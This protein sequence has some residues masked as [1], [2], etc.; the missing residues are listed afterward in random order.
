MEIHGTEHLDIAVVFLPPPIK[1]TFSGTLL[2][3]KT[4][5]F[6]LV[7]KSD[8]LILRSFSLHNHKFD[9]G[10][11]I[12]HYEFDVFANSDVLAACENA[13]LLQKFPHGPLHVG[14]KPTFSQLD[15][16]SPRHHEMPQQQQYVCE[17]KASL[18][19]TFKNIRICGDAN[20]CLA[21]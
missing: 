15:E 14:Q 4:R 6:T 2:K 7:Y 17:I 21:K 16:S 12:I 11:K 10:S 9:S 8:S 20:T 3:K 19:K 13:S 18:R 5:V 1:T